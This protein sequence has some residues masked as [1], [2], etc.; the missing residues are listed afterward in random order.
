M[1]CIDKVHLYGQSNQPEDSSGV[2]Q[3][4]EDLRNGQIDLVL[5]GAN[6]TTATVIRAA[7]QTIGLAPGVERVSGGFVMIPP[8][9]KAQAYPL[10][11]ADC[12][13]NISP[14]SH[15]LYEIA[16]QSFL[17][18]EKLRQI[19][20]P[21][22]EQPSRLAFLSFS[23]GGSAQHKSIEKIRQ[24]HALFHR[25]FPRVSS[26]GEAQVDAA[27]IPQIGAQKLGA[28]RLEGPA[29]V[30]IF[31][32]L[33]SGNIAYKF[34]ERLGNYTAVGPLL[35]GTAMPFCDVSRGCNSED[36]ILATLIS[37]ALGTPNTPI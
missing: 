33:N 4:G 3:A 21:G 8:E 14:S 11:F 37:S 10:I 30:F 24:A 5:A 27:L 26:C 28:N 17:N 2:I 20:V 9:D 1:A 19:G 18:R 6:C 31:P 35:Q 25:A 12:A 36:I 16:K 15:Q 22:F 32:D 7:I 29:N 34:L 23:S 13:V